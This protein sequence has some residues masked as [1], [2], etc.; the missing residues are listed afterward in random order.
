MV[1]GKVEKVNIWLKVKKCIDYIVQK[2]KNRYAQFTKL[3]K[4]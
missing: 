4:N 1:C 3:V 2:L